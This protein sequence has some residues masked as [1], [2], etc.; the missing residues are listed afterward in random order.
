MGHKRP[1]GPPDRR[2]RSATLCLTAASHGARGEPDMTDDHFLTTE[3][4]LDYLQ[5]NLRT[6]YRLT[7]AGKIPAVRVGRQWRFR[8]E[9]VDA[10]LTADRSDEKGAGVPAR[11]RILIVDDE[12]QV[13]ELLAKTLSSVDYDVDT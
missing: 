9:V 13:R 4:V 8:K 1:A 12:Q 7:K 11:P 3:E 2:Q 6:I 5:V 10:W